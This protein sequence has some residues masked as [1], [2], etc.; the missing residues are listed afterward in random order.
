[1]GNPYHHG[2]MVVADFAPVLVMQ[3]KSKSKKRDK[4]KD[5]KKKKESKVR[6]DVA[7]DLSCVSA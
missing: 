2:W 1:M 6:G 5:K 3:K 4:K 7:A